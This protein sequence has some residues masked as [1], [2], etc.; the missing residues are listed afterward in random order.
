MTRNIGE[1]IRKFLCQEVAKGFTTVKLVP[2]KKVFKD[3]ILYSCIEGILH[4]SFYIVSYVLYILFLYNAL[5]ILFLYNVLYILFLLLYFLLYYILLRPRNDIYRTRATQ[6]S[7]LAYSLAH[8][9]AHSQI[10]TVLCNTETLIGNTETQAITRN[11]N[12]TARK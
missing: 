7:T 4:V 2:E 1:I 6:G 12:T 11:D 8:T 3:T 9:L 10:I 5:Y